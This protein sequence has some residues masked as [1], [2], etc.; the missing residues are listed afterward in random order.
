MTTEERLAGIRARNSRPSGAGGHWGRDLE[1]LRWLLE[2]VDEQKMTLGNIALEHLKTAARLKME[3]A[4][5]RELENSLEQAG[6]ML[7]GEEYRWN[8]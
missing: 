2:L 8:T 3:Q 4:R 6:E 7:M 1:D 5:V